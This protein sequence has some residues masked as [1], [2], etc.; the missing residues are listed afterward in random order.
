MSPMVSCAIVAFA[1]VVSWPWGRTFLMCLRPQIIHADAACVIMLGLLYS[2]EPGERPASWWRS[3]LIPCRRGPCAHG[4]DRNPLSPLFY[5]PLGSPQEDTARPG[6]RLRVVG[7]RR[8]R[9]D[10]VL[11]IW[12]HRDLHAGRLAL[13][14]LLGGASSHVVN[15]TP[16]NSVANTAPPVDPLFIMGTINTEVANEHVHE[17]TRN[18]RQPTPGHE[19]RLYHYPLLAEETIP[20]TRAGKR[21]WV[22]CWEESWGVETLREGRAGPREW[23]WHAPSSSTFPSAGTGS[24]E[25]SPLRVVSG[26]LPTRSRRGAAR[27]DCPMIRRS[28]CFGSQN[29]SPRAGRG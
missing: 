4:W 6:N 15:Y 3:S 10:Q 21:Q 12:G 18:R 17:R 20:E 1:R 14:R 24:P 16:K 7:P 19:P 5:R 28:A 26:R 23:P 11:F 22:G 2:A 9:P 25:C 29:P 27:T 13:I 8:R